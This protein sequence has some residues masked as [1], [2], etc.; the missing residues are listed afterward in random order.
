MQCNV[1]DVAGMYIYLKSVLRCKFLIFGY[2]SSAQTIATWARLWGSVVIFRSKM[3]SA[4]KK[5]WG[6]LG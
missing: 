2:L 1:T 3:G 5:V 6:T 4:R